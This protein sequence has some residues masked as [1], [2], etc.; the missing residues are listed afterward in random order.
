MGTLIVTKRESWTETKKMPYEQMVNQ[1]I[2]QVGNTVDIAKR[3]RGQKKTKAV[4]SVNLNSEP[5]EQ[6]IAGWLAVERFLSSAGAR[7]AGKMKVKR[8]GNVEVLMIS[9]R[10]GNLDKMD[11]KMVRKEMRKARA[12]VKKFRETHK[13]THREWV[14][15]N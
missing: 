15:K 2:A 4:I 10:V 8:L 12:E 13:Y 1:L 11:L 6:S 3:V 7:V 9:V 14:P 5:Q